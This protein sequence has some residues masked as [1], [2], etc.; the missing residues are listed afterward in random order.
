MKTQR[1]IAPHPSQVTPPEVAKAPCKWST[2]PPD[3]DRILGFQIEEL[4]FEGRYRQFVENGRLV[5]EFPRAQMWRNGKKSTV[6][7]WC[8]NDYLGMG[9]HSAVLEAMKAAIDTSVPVPVLSAALYSRFESRG[10]AE[11]AS[12]L[13]SA[14]RFQFGGHR[15]TGKS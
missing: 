3:Y 10:E 6:T 12:R 13:L 1:S 7:V 2:E 14:M 4:K 5:G 11:F 15:E 9:Q 8:S